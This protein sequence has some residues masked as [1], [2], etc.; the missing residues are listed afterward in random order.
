MFGPIDYVLIAFPGNDFNGAI[1]PEIE[2]LEESGTIKVIDI[3]FIHKDEEGAVTTIEAA[4][5]PAEIAD[6]LMTARQEIKDLLTEEDI[7]SASDL[8]DNNSSA[9]VL[10]YENVWAKG[11]KT[12]IIESGGILVSDGR[13]SDQEYTDAIDDEATANEEES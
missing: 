11:L 7:E 12:A 2:R 6:T 5:M 8:L 3:V 1:L 13:I 10:V 9:G 4:D